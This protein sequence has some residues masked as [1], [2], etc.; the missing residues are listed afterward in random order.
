[1]TD[2]RKARVIA[3][4]DVKGEHV[5]NTFQ[6]EGQ[7]KVDRADALAL[8][9]YRDGADELLIVDQVA[10]LY[11]RGHLLEMTRMFA[12]N[13]FAPLTVGGGI[14]TADEARALLRSGADKVAV[15]TAA[16]H[17]PD[18]LSEISD[19]FGVQC[20]VLSVQAKLAGP[21]RWE[22]YCDGGRERTGRDVLEWVC[23]AVE[24]G[25][26]EVLVTSI[27]RDGTRQGFELELM[28]QVSRAVT[29]P[30]IASGGFGVPAHGVELLSQ[31]GCEAFACADYFHAKRGSVSDVKSGLSA[32]GFEVRH[33]R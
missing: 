6:L 18:L 31:T 10:S 3:R 16:V 7:R 8:Q 15:N 27:D 12:E 19:L 13:V 4:L 14:Q 11:Q 33:V 26:G 20:M 30:V 32:A 25:A 28:A 22:A 23:E 24:R 2:T 5:V 29:V 17:R 9:Y 1:M 21:G